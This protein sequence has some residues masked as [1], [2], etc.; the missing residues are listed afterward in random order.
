MRSARLCAALGILGVAC[1]IAGARDTPLDAASGGVEPSRPWADRS[2]T[3][4]A[5][6]RLYLLYGDYIGSGIPVPIF[7]AISPPGERSP[8][9]VS[10]EGPSASLPRGLNRFVMPS[11]VEVVAGSTCLA[12]HSQELG[13]E[14]VIGLGNSLGRYHDAVGFDATVLRALTRFRFGPRSPEY[15]A[16][17]QFVRGAEAVSAAGFATPFAGVN[18]AFRFEEVAAAHRN[19]ED[20]TWSDERR[21]EVMDRFYASDVPPWWHVRKKSKLY[22]TGLGRGAFSK[23]IQQ[24]IVVGISDAEHAE[25]IQPHMQDLLAYIRTIEPPAYPGEIDHQLA[26]AGRAV[27]ENSCMSCHGTYGEAWTYPNKIVPLE[28]IGT[29]PEYALM[30]ARSGLD[31]WFNRSW[32]ATTEPRAEAGSELG[33]IAPPLDGVW[34]TAPYFH[35]GSVPTLEGVIDS[36]KRPAFWRR[37]FDPDD[38]DVDAPGWTHTVEPGPT[39]PFTYDTTLR[40]YSNAGHTFGDDLS[41]EARR[42]LLEYL[43]SL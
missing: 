3:A 4:E 42:A 15:A 2:L 25:R 31:E 20:L 41:G 23:L 32:F 6:G 17:G 9:L 14:L 33:Y 38:Y 24:I 13:G 43:K 8:S 26:A 37:G 36:S 7:D 35:N 29:D 27:F 22:Y 1:V 21:F 10:R 34:A 5:R 18:P 40:G 30:F 11:G 19:P 28:K 12:C 39:D 16:L